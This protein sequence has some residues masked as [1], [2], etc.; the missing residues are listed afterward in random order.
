MLEISG[1]QSG[2]VLFE[3]KLK[4]TFS[5]IV[6]Q[7][8]PLELLMEFASSIAFPMNFPFLFLFLVV[9]GCLILSTI[10]DFF[11]FFLIS[12]LILPLCSCAYQHFSFKEYYV[13]KEIV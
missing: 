4:G 2:C 1:P 9:F 3:L 11:F 5:L 12:L 6:Y 8:K 13:V 7:S 10:N